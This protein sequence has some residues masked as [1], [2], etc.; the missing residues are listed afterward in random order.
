MKKDR[1]K[2][3]KWPEW[4]LARVREFAANRKGKGKRTATLKVKKSLPC[5]HVG[6][7]LT[8]NEI[9]A[10]GLKETRRWHRC[11]VGMAK[12]ELNVPGISCACS[13]CGPKCEGYKP[14]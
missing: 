11:E 6:E 14:Q 8:M 10:A 4:S 9:K 13:G 7:K 12:N 2:E 3:P 5:I 1:S